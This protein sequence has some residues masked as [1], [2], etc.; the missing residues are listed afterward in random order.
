[1]NLNRLLVII[2]SAIM[3]QILGMGIIG[4]VVFVFGVLNKC[5]LLGNCEV[6]KTKNTKGIN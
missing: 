6:P 3:H 1:M 5:L 2:I 4:L